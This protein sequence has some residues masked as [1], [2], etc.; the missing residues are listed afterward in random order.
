VFTPPDRLSITV[1]DGREVNHR[2]TV[3]GDDA[4]LQSDLRTNYITRIGETEF[5]EPVIDGWRS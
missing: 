1:K 2:F 3:D 4:E 5:T